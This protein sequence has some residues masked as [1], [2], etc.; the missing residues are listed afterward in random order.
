[1]M[2]PLDNQGAPI[3][4]QCLMTIQLFRVSLPFVIKSILLTVFIVFGSLC[5]AVLLHPD[6]LI[7]D[8]AAVLF[9]AF[10]ILATN[11]QTDLGLGIISYLMWLDVFNGVQ[12]TLVFIVRL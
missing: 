5:F 9:V 7:G 12:L 4:N 3:R 8:R 11:F 2:H 1:M 10:L 6:E